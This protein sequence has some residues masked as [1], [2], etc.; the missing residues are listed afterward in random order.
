MNLLSSKNRPEI[1][2]KLQSEEFDLTIIGGGITGAGI[3]LDAASRGMKVALVEMK[4]FASGT[5]SKSTKLVHGGLRYLKQ[6]ELS[7]VREVGRERAIVHKLAPHLTSA[8]KMLLPI[9]KNG[10]YGRFA[11]SIGLMVY[12]FLAEV[13][14]VDKRRM[15]SKE[16][17]LE[18]E[19][20]LK[21][22]DLLGGGVYAEYRT[23]DARLTIEIIKEAA[24]FGAISLNYLKAKKFVYDGKKVIGVKC[25]DLISE[26][27]FE[28][29]SKYIVSAAGPWV[30]KL[31]KK[32]KSL[33]GKRLFLSKGAHL[34]VPHERLPLKHAIYFD[35]PDGRMMFAI[36]RHRIT[37][38][39][40]TDTPY[41]GDIDKVLANKA[42]AL[43]ILDSVNSRF[44]NVKLT[45]EDIESSW[46]GLRPLIYE[47]GKSASEMSRKDEIFKS[48]SGLISI[49]GGKLTGY[50]KMA[51]RIVDLVA[52]KFQK[53]EDRTFKEC[54]T[55]KIPLGKSNFQN[56]T[57]VAKYQKNVEKALM[58]MGLKKYYA[59]YLVA[60]YGKQ[61]DQILE[62]IKGYNDS[63]DIALARAEL[64]F[65][66]ENELCCTPLDFF[67]SPNGAIVF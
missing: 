30:D 47:E 14:E 6:L 52:K 40:T 58:P 42:D 16:D 8:E 36:P 64:A 15:I 11:S 48:K 45:L 39:G 19:P 57:K 51:E 41:D 43:Y 28:I 22:D 1:I 55:D 13:E 3:A 38:L 27:S 50:R 29:K 35:V 61:T 46:A 56:A 20:L 7:L 53:R 62:L 63:S 49:A 12:D 60:N 4:D 23:D 21:A 9:I 54:H 18:R 32:D 24:E 44:P 67:R 17:V 5:S 31:R 65:C 66:L 10:T 37:Y 25:Q 34:V 59:Q 2:Q 33:K 26:A